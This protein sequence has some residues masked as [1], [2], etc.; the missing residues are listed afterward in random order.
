M[1]GD[2]HT[3]RKIADNGDQIAENTKPGKAYRQSLVGFRNRLL[4]YFY[5]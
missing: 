1:P 3:F 2:I 4:K 5:D